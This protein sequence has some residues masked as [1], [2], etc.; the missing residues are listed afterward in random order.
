MFLPEPRHLPCTQC[1]TSIERSARDEH[2]CRRDDIVRFELFRLRYEI[3]AF[4]DQL[5][6]FMSSPQGRFAVWDA[7][8][9]RR[10]DR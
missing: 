6:A 9:R 5:G 2:E 8:R 3:A 1:G 7:E 10:H 4:D